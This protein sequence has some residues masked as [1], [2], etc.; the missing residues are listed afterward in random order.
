MDSGHSIAVAVANNSD[1]CTLV[2]KKGKATLITVCYI[3]EINLKCSDRELLVR[4]MSQSISRIIQVV[5]HGGCLQGETRLIEREFSCVRVVIPLLHR[6]QR[7]TPE[8]AS[9][10]P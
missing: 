9:A 10:D 8:L 4:P 5:S 2:P 3:S 7:V 1:L 6:S